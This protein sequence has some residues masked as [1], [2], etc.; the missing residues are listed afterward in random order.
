MQVSIVS[1]LR[2][3][4]CQSF[5]ITSVGLLCSCTVYE[6]PGSPVG[7]GSAAVAD[8]AIDA[9]VAAADIGLAAAAPVGFMGG[10]WWGGGAYQQNNYYNHNGRRDD[11][12]RNGY[13]HHRSYGAYRGGG[14]RGGGFRGGRR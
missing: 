1:S 12:R 9:G 10:G 2:R 14:Y 13:Y 11:Y 5:I 4:L 8:G 3:F 7:V 6:G